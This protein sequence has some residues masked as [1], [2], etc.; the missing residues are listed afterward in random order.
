MDDKEY[1]KILEDENISLQFKLG[2]AKKGIASQI[3]SLIR[4]LSFL[5]PDA[6]INPH[7]EKHIREIA[8]KD[9]EIEFAAIYI[10]VLLGEYEKEYPSAE[11]WLAR[12]SNLKRQRKK[13]VKKIKTH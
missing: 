1:I 13:H 11:E 9:K 7:M 10:S 2:V 4:D 3:P 5:F 8:K 12:N 6:T